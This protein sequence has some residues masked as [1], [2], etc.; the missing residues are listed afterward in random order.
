[1]FFEHLVKI[2]SFQQQNNLPAYAVAFVAAEQA[3]VALL[4]FGREPFAVAPFLCLC[5]DISNKNLE[6]FFGALLTTMIR[7]PPSEPDLRS[8]AASPL[9]FLKD[10]AR[11]HFIVSLKT[12]RSFCIGIWAN[13]LAVV[14][15]LDHYVFRNAGCSHEN[16]LRTDIFVLH[17]AMG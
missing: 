5:H 1:M 6:H 3:R 4:Q 2:C 15:C 9:V 14:D 8:S 11:E 10:E 7:Y 16:I 12:F 13:S 17:W